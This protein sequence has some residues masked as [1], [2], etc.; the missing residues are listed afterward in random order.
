MTRSGLLRCLKSG[1]SPDAMVVGTGHVWRRKTICD[2]LERAA[3]YL[4]F[5]APPEPLPCRSG[6]G[7][8]CQELFAGSSTTVR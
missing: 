8:F 5:V 3:Q 7:K 4:V 6:N 1:V 2:D